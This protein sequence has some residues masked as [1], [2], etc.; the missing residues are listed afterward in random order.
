MPDHRYVET[1]GVRLHVLQDGRDD[2]PLVI[3]L[4]GFPEFS[5]CWTRLID[6]LATAEYRVWA[7][8]GR[9]YNLSDK[10]VGVASYS[11]DALVADVV[12]LVDA[13]GRE[14]VLLVGHDWGAS[15][16]WQVAQQHP[17]RVSRLVIIN[18]PHAAVMKEHLRGNIAQVL[19]SWYVFFFQL[20]WLP[21]ALLR[22][23]GWRAL[24]Q[25]MVAT[26]RPGTFSEREMAA[27]RAAWSQPKAIGSM[28]NW[29]RAL[30]WKPP[31]GTPR[32][33]ITVPTLVLWGA[34]DAFLSRDMARPSVELCD[35]GR[36]VVFEDATHWVHHEEPD[37]VA[38]SIAA[39]F[40]AA[41]GARGARGRCGASPGPSL[42]DGRRG[43]SCCLTL[44][45]R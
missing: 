35:D 8:D 3:L 33:R 6:F 14:R 13:A 15:V 44:R 16:A 38:E 7:P 17:D 43:R 36:L 19:K 21:E 1:N 24:A 10:P 34:R 27:Y 29:Y 41:R 28:I 37:H 42:S 9:G 23:R 26:S 30:L 18:V 31:A 20:P 40:G 22:R 11:L 4:H 12:G 39:F 2:G 32:P 45:D 5:G 25:G